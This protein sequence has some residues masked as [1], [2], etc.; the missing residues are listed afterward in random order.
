[1]DLKQFTLLIGVASLPSMAT[2]ATVYRTISKVSVVTVD[3]PEGT[4][5]RLPNLVWVTYS[6]GYSEYRQVRWANAPLADEQAEADAHKHP[7]G[8]QYEIGGFVIG[9]ETTDNGYPVKAQIKVVAEGYK[10]PEKEVAHTFSLADVSIDGDNRLSH[11]RDEALREICSWDVTQQLY[12]YR[13]TYGLSTE[14]YTKSDGWDS[15]DTKL[16]GHGSGHYMS[17][18]AQAYAVATNPEQK[19]ILR[20]NITRMV[21]ELR[22]CQEKTFVYN[23]EL[24]RNWEARDFAPEAELREMKGTWDAF[25]EYKKHPELYGYGYINAIPAQHCALIE[26]YRAYNNSDWVW[27]PYYSVHKQLAGLIDIATYF[28]DKEICDKALLIAKDMGLWV[29]NRMHYRTYVKQDGTQDERRAKPGNR[30]EMW[31]M[32]IAGEVG[33]MSESLARLSEMVSNPDEKAKLLE[34]ANC[35]DAPK[36]YDPL[37]KNID[38]IRTRHAN[39]HI[40]MIIGALRSYKSNQKPYYYN[41]AENFWRLVQGRYMY[42]MGGVGNGEMF[43]Q[44]Y[45]Q[46]LSMATNGLQ[47]GESEA[48]PDINETCCAY[49]LVKL[50]KDLNCYNPDNAQY[51]DYIERTLYNQIIGSLNPDQYQTCYQYAVGLNATKPFGNETPQSTCCGGTGSENHTKYQQSAYFAND[52]T[53]W[54]GLYMPTTLRWKEK[55]VTIKQDCLWPAQHSAIKITEGEGD[56]TL[57]LRVPYW[58]T[59]GFSIKV[60]GKEVAKSYQPSTYVELEQKHWKAGDVVEI[61]MPFSKHIEYGADKL[62]SDVASL[63]G[64]PLKTSWVGTLMYGPLVMAGTGAQ[65]WNQATLNIDSKLNNITV[66]ESNGVTTGAGANLLTLKLDGKEFQPDYYRNANSTHYYRINLTDAKS[67]KSKKVKIDFTELNSLLNLAAERKADQEKWNALSQKVPE[68]APWAPFGYERMQKVM[69][70]AQE[71]VSKGKKKV[72]QDELEGTT[73]ILNRAINTMRPGNLA[74][75]EDLRELSGLLRRAGWPDDNTSEEL[76]DAIS[77]GRMVQKYVTDGSGTHDMIHAAVGKLKKAMK[78]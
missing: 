38:D 34:A 16:K 55:G 6:D 25:D 5:P 65:T 52:H 73:A 3:C 1:M 69:A 40:P 59:Q 68:Y 28:D 12:N 66:G 10:T 32:Y 14:G 50:S 18:I 31:D 46:I 70:L 36:F 47:E 24:K 9:D 39:Q 37:S 15:P 75:M 72:T 17:A 27:A 44:P 26:M 41:L 11:N 67:K 61:D 35:F 56:F 77:Y 53:L 45:T 48:Y 30:Y 8:S 78:Q 51:L 42:A 57:K 74:E 71:L 60:N 21:N 29:W 62:S 76:K 4:A 7:A 54:V 64:T 22:E 20:K 49:N 63:D 19:A 58:A 43:R 33:G 23:K 13:D 2:A